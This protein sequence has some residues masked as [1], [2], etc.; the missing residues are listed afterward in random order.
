MPTDLRSEVKVIEAGE[1]AAISSFRAVGRAPLY[2]VLPSQGSHQ[3]ERRKTDSMPSCILRHALERCLKHVMELFLGE[4][5]HWGRSG[6]P[7]GKTEYT[8][9]TSHH[10][11]RMQ[12][13]KAPCEGTLLP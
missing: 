12:S 8:G 3:P 10:S 7:R 9:K 13:Q 5:G 1:T 11:V 4:K 2:G 6:E